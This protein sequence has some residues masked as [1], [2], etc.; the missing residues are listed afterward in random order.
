MRSGSGTALVAARLAACVNIFPGMISIYEWKGARETA[1]EVAMIIKTRRSLADAVLA[2]TKRLHPYELPALTR[3]SDRRWQRRILRLDP[4]PHRIRFMSGRGFVL[5]IDQGTTSTR[6]IVFDS[7]GRPCASAQVPLT[8]I[9]PAPGEVEHDPEEI[10][11]SVL[12]AGRAAL[13]D[14]GAQSVAAIGITNQRETTIVWER[15]T[16]KPLANAIVWQ[17]RR[18][19]RHCEELKSEGWGRMSQ[20]QPGSS[21]ILISPAPSLPGCWPMSPDSASGRERARCASA[22]STAFSLCKLTGGKVHAIE[23]SNAARTMLHD[24]RRGA[25]DDR[26]LDRLAIPRAILPELRDSQDDFGEAEP[27]L[28]GAAHP[29]QRHRRRSAG[30][31]LWAG[32]LLPGML[33][34]TYGTG[35]FLLA[36]TGEA[37][38]ASTARMLATVSH[39]LEGKRTF[40]LEGSIFMAGATVQWLRNSL[41]LI[42]DAAESEALARRADPKSGVYLV[43]AF[44]GLGAPHWDA[45]ARAAILGLTRAASAA[46]IVAPG[47][48]LSPSRPAICSTPCAR[49]WRKAPSRIPRACGWMAA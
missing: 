12:K 21:S 6:A 46:D 3:A 36:N 20:R 25:W 13:K 39:Q 1:D 19:A 10:W 28:F 8:Q 24:I 4:G 18:T 27:A 48:R 44:Q 14:T 33:K 40:A 22:R 37:K 31:G 42:A 23:A 17:D 2:E 35:C 43:P 16:G 7:E 32:L 26:L 29:D 41:G 5:A 30:G 38:I 9:Y 34:T 49:T 11:Q 45:E 47:S 15:A